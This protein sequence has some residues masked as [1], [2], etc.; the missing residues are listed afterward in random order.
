MKNISLLSALLLLAFS[1]SAQTV[2]NDYESGN[3]SV[4]I[5]NCWAFGGFSV[6]TSGAL[7]GSSSARS[8]SLNNNPASF[9]LQ[10][11]WLLLAS[12]DITLTTAL[13]SNDGSNGYQMIVSFIPYDANASFGQGTPFA[14]TYT[15][16]YSSPHS[17]AQSTNFAI[18][19]AIANSST[20]YKVMLNFVS[21]AGNR[22]RRALVDNWSIPGTYYADPAANCLPQQNIT[23]SDGD[24]V[25]DN[26]D[27]YPNDPERAY[28]FYLNG[29]GNF[30]SMAFEDLYPARGDYDFN[31][32]VLD[33]SL[34]AVVNADNELKDVEGRMVVRALGGDLIRGFGVHMPLLSPAEV[35]SVTGQ[36][37]STGDLNIAANG[38]EN[39][40]SNAVIIF[41]DDVN[42]IV[43]RAG[44]AFHNSISSNPR[45]SSDTIDFSMTLVNAVAL[46]RVF[47]QESGIFVFK[48]RS[49]EIHFANK[50]PTDLMDQSIFGTGDDDSDPAANRYFVTENNL[51]W[52]LEVP[53][54]FAY[55]EE[56]EDIIGAYLNFAN[57]AQSNGS[58]S[59]DWYLDLPGY[60]DNSKL[61][62][63]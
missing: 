29:P 52:A 25:D 13:N 9:W 61:F 62:Q 45:G 4:D 32:F 35:A 28:R 54:R 47:G 3:R 31:D 50:Q 30:T 59:Q 23:D 10:S 38:T 24:G 63:E 11:P 46:E 55:P 42:A 6:S 19:A 22:N 56:K 2:S 49:Q 17:S 14:T 53:M 36:V 20:P 37:L 1:S 41:C 21:L 43:N 60:R 40:Q 34:A 18:P 15:Y 26:N 58:A 27:E 51:P 8:G 16:N 7:V 33:M 44:G 39:G 48:Q 5:A 57:W 12:G